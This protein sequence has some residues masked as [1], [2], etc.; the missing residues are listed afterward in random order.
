MQNL[1]PETGISLRRLIERRELLSSELIDISPAVR[2][3]LPDVAEWDANSA[4]SGRIIR[5]VEHQYGSL[6]GHPLAH[7]GPSVLSDSGGYARAQNVIGLAL[8]QLDFTR[9]A[10][11]RASLVNSGSIPVSANLALAEA[12]RLLVD[13]NLA[14]HLDCLDPNSTGSATLAIDI[15]HLGKLR[16]MEESARSTARHW[17][18]PPSAEDTSAALELARRHETS[19][20]R[21]LSGDWRRLKS[22][23]TERYDF[24]EHA[25]R[26]SIASVLE[27]LTALHSAEATSAKKE[28]EI[29]E[30]LRT[31][32][33]AQFLAVREKLSND[34]STNGY[35]RALVTTTAQQP[36]PQAILAA[37][38]RPLQAL[39]ALSQTLEQS[40]FGLSEVTLDELFH[41]LNAIHE[42]LGDLPDLQPHLVAIHQAGGR[43]ADSVLKLGLAID[44]LEVAVLDEGIARILRNEPELRAFTSRDMTETATRAGKARQI[45]ATANSKVLQAGRHNQLLANIRQSQLSVSQ[46]DNQGRDFKRL[47]STG[48]RELEHEFGKTMRYRSIRDLT[49]GETGLVISDLKPVWLM[50]PLSVS[51]ALPLEPDLFDIVI[52]DE[53][54][55]IPM[56]DAVPA[57]CRAP[58]AVIVGD[59]HQLP[60]TS[61]F[62]AQLDDDEM[63]ISA[64]DDGEKVSILM[65]AD[66]LLIQAAR[67]L[68]GTMLT[69]HYRS[70]AESLISFSN[71]AFYSSGLITIPD[72]K[73]SSLSSGQ[74][75][76]TETLASAADKV[77][78]KPISFHLLQGGQ[79]VNR[80]NPKEAETIALMVR[81][82]LGKK[83]DKS[84]GIVAF[85]E[86]QQSEIEDA[87]T[88]LSQDDAAF[89][90]ALEK[91]YVREDDGQFNGLFIK[92]LENVQGDERDIII[93]SICYGPDAS[94]RMAMN[95]GPINQRGGEK[96]LNVIFS[97]SKHHMAI[98][99]SIQGD[100]ITNTHND[101][102]L[103]LRRFLEFAEAQSNGAV[104]K[105]QAV[106]A[107]LNSDARSVFG[108]GEAIDPTRSALADALRMR[109]HDVAE[110][111]GT[112]RFRCDLAVASDGGGEYQLGV[113]IDRD[114]ELSPSA[115]EDY[116]VFRP[117]ILR[118][119]GWKIV[120]V[121]ALDWACNRDAVLSRLEAILDGEGDE[122][123]DDDPFEGKEKKISP[124][125]KIW[126]A[127]PSVNRTT[128]VTP[129]PQ[130]P[131]SFTEFR[132]KEGASDKFWKIA[133]SGVDVTVIFGREGTKGNTVIKS[134]ENAARAKREANKLI[135]EKTRK[136]YVEVT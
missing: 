4:L 11:T 70:N 76:A 60:P 93:L 2:E 53:A 118:A 39:A 85:S 98:V 104:E 109:G 6:S 73:I 72:R 92:N 63:R 82:I 87:L 18:N 89:A 1:S 22:M 38:S 10:M 35:V 7:L 79:Y 13:T 30:R 48:R 54:S 77:L 65:D 69:W 132:F 108:R 59:E 42:A 66:S 103:A 110:M 44:N 43:Y 97:R 121:S 101:G 123:I 135:L 41:T 127:V 74:Q 105:A 64:E 122:D 62:S 119:F 24:S 50:S 116:R 12:A 102:A 133:V 5:M 117:G 134:Y 31:P 114:V 136:G 107:S 56:E 19:F 45:L 28:T 16:Q 131:A 111:V 15:Q 23:V 61:F 84:I 96:R 37:Q 3:R 71:A 95:F 27:K 120:T 83:T 126:G 67:N 55:Q 130:L 26:P 46:L 129:S 17:R 86:A 90:T 57:L 20:F 49:D 32:E 25:V 33:L 34:C 106:L 112:A 113:L 91:E 75:S 124:P 78:G 128:P 80:T 40:F 14:A 47:Y 81:G 94:G 115:I 8:S 88:R 99:T 100:R 9:E 51:D 29:E 68:D 58:Q 125:S 52:F 36:D 21:I